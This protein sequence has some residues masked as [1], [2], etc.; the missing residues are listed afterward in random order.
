M[1]NM[2]VRLHLC[3]HDTLLEMFLNTQLWAHAPRRRKQKCLGTTLCLK[4]F[5]KSTVWRTMWLYINQINYINIINS[6]L[7]QSNTNQRWS[8]AGEGTS[9][10]FSQT[11]APITEKFFISPKASS[12]WGRICRLGREIKIGSEMR[13]WHTEKLRLRALYAENSWCCHAFIL[14]P[15]II[16][17]ASAVVQLRL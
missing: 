7:S 4:T 10:G 16:H 14:Y 9:T 2:F 8:S 12:S 1:R 15:I 6:T 5:A 11:R 13:P 3:L 17:Q